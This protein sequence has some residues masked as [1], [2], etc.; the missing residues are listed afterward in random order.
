MKYQHVDF[1]SKWAA[2]KTVAEFVK[3]ESHHGL[4]EEQLREVHAICVE[5]QKPGAS[6]S[7]A[8][9]DID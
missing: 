8:D 4:S 9:E 2:S 7:P 6:E 3:H 5:K 1:N